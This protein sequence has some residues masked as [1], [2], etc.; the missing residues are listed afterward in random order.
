MTALGTLPDSQRE[1]V[2]L[3]F[4]GGL[5]AREIARVA[6]IPLGTAKSRIRLGLEK[7]RETLEAAA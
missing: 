1:A 6:D 7:A 4:G 3:A 2:L 5:T